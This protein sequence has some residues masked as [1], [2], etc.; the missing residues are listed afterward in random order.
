MFCVCVCSG[1]WESLDELRGVY[2]SGKQWDPQ[3]DPTERELLVCYVMVLYGV[4]CYV[5]LYYDMF[6]YVMLCYVMLCYIFSV[7]F[8]PFSLFSFTFLFLVLT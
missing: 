2:R 3:S 1:Y 7:N 5:M 8:F 6:C 4:A